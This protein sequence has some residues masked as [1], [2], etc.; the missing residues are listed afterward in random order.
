MTDTQVE[1]IVNEIE[2]LRKEVSELRTDVSELRKSNDKLSRE[3]NSLHLKLQSARANTKIEM[4]AMRNTQSLNYRY[5]ER[6]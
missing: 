2:T 5:N 1:L 4:Q 3:N 6:P